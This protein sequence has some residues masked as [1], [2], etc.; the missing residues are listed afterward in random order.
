V[1]PDGEVTGGVV[2]V[3]PGE[4]LVPDAGFSM[5]VEIGRTALDPAGFPE[6]NAFVAVTLKLYS[7]PAVRPLTVVDVVEPP[8]TVLWPPGLAVT[9][10]TK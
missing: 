7:T 1:V 2:A 6:P 4:L 3:P 8:T 10:C 5:G 9:V